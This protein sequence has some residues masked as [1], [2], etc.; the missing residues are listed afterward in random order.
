V[1]ALL[2]HLPECLTIAATGQKSAE[3]LLAG[4]SGAT[5]APIP[6]VGSS[7]KAEFAIP[8]SPLSRKVTVWRM[9]STSRAYPMRMEE[10]AEHYRRMFAAVGA[11]FQIENG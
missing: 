4:V 9:P 10:K 1:G 3:T 11:F 8:N 6:A 5:G 2:A 7:V